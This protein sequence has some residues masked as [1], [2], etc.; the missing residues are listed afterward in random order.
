MID[1]INKSNESIRQHIEN[2]MAVIT[3]TENLGIRSNELEE[4]LR[5][6]NEA[7]GISN[8]CVCLY[9]YYYLLCIYL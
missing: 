4:L 1:F 3:L 7:M 9:Y 2:N 8:K 6:M 5:K